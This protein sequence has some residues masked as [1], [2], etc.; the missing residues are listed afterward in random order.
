MS[1]DFRQGIKY[2]LIFLDAT[3]RK[4]DSWRVRLSLN[5]SKRKGLKFI[6]EDMERLGGQLE[7]GAVTYVIGMASTIQLS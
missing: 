4:G 1:K 5:L 2:Y 7:D 3:D 6:K